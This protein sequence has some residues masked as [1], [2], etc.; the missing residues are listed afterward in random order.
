[1]TRYQC[2]IIDFNLIQ[3]KSISKGFL[4]ITDDDFS[5]FLI[6]NLNNSISTVAKSF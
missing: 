4:S 1:M 2:Q 3:I 6:I 5:R